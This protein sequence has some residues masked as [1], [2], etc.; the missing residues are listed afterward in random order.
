MA[1]GGRSVWSFLLVAS[2]LAGCAGKATPSIDDPTESID[3]SLGS[4]AGVVVDEESIPVGDAEVG[5]S[6]NVTANVRTDVNGAFLL[7]N[8]PQGRY[9]LSASKAGFH[10]TTITVE[11]GEEED[12][13]GMVITL[14]PVI[15]DPDP[16][17]VPFTGSGFI[18]C[19][20]NQ[21][22]AGLTFTH[23]CAFDPN[24]QPYF[25]FPVNVSAGLV[26][27]LL[28]M[29]WTPT[30]SFTAQELR[31]MLWKD[32]VCAGVR[33]DG[34]VMGGNNGPSPRR[35]VL[36]SPTTPLRHSLTIGAEDY[37]AAMALV[38]QADDVGANP[39]DTHIVFQQQVDFYINVFYR[40]AVP[41]DFTG[42]P[43]D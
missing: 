19:S 38:G 18:S 9:S 15:E 42:L 41:E 11:V 4:V 43:P 3:P 21:A 8:V 23:P 39:T 27:V 20:V 14:H 34:Q 30:T 6:D 26:G 31:L 5:I 2:V 33:C 32:P 24:Y 17:Y 35:L 37:V 28:E 10:P 25:E 22:A 36:G 29:E 16:T 7:A 13:E 40:M 1:S 12:V